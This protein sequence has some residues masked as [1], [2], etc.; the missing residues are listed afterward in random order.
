M[1]DG[2]KETWGKGITP[3]TRDYLIGFGWIIL[4]IYSMYY[5][6]RTDTPIMPTP[7]TLTVVIFIPL[8]IFIA[9]SSRE[10]RHA[11]IVFFLLFLAI[12]S[13]TYLVRYINNSQP[14]RYEDLTWLFLFLLLYSARSIRFTI[15]EIISHAQRLA[16][17]VMRF[18]RKA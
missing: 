17:T 12:L 2:I 9:R 13:M 1:T 14:W 7:V 8:L 15:S 3:A 6:T 4:I 10:D 11:L 18:N 5:Y 16:L